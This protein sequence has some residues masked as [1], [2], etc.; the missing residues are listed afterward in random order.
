[1]KEKKRKIKKAQWFELISEFFDI[2]LSWV[3]P[4]IK[5]GPDMVADDWNQL[6]PQTPEEIESFYYKNKTY[7]FDLIGWHLWGP[8]KAQDKEFMNRIK[9]PGK[10]LDYGC[11]AGF[12]SLNLARKGHDVTLMDFDNPPFK[13]AKFVA[14]KLELKCEFIT[15][16]EM[17][18]NIEL[19]TGTFDYILCL[20]VL[21]H[22]P[23]PLK[24]CQNINT[25]LHKNGKV[26]M[27]APF[28][29]TEDHPMHLELNDE[30][31][32][33]IKLIANKVIID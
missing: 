14:E 13:F 31:K 11:G 23:N 19:Q 17:E 24:I 32:E 33:G 8:K 28:G 26:L 4:L 1:M 16:N 9:K 10:V 18:E 6:N 30:A 7:V 29:K 12:I 2:P 25:L 21:E 5:A 27:T 3:E 15:V 22:A 20:D